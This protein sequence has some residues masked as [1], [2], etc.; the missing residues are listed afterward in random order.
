MSKENELDERNRVILAML[1]ERWPDCFAIFEQ[2]RRPLKI[3]IH[4][5]ILAALDGTVTAK[6]LGAALRCYT[7][8]SVYWSQLRAGAIRI[9]LDG[10]P[11]GEV[12]AD[13]VAR[14]AKPKPAVTAAKPASAKRTSMADL[15]ESV[16][17]RREAAAG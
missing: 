8:N 13:Q 10:R 6:G 3:G 11:A 5:E 2:R 15:R 1:A 14:A 4:H 9:D 16:R 17:R 7:G 12:T